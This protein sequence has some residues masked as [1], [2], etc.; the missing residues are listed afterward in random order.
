[1]KHYKSWS[2]LNKQLHECLCDSLRNRVSYFLTRY[3]K[4]HNSYGRA[5]IKLDGRE[6][7]VFSWIDMYKQDSDM[8]ERWK[9]TGVWDDTLDL[10]NKWQEEGTLSDWDFLQAATDFLQMPIADALISDN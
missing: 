1:M 2:G 10:R 5:S 3:H 8:N 9:E 4:V 7:V 6:L